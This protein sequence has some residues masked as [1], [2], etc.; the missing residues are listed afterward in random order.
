M[1]YEIIIFVVSCEIICSIVESIDQEILST[2]KKSNSESKDILVA[3]KFVVKLK[4][5]HSSK[6]MA[7]GRLSWNS[8]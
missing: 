8:V 2:V 5:G 3:F 4:N 6:N 7:L 1:K